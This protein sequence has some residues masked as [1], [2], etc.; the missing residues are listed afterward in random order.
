MKNQIASFYE[1]FGENDAK[2]EVYFAPGRVCLIGEHLDYNGGFVLPAAL[3]IGIYGFVRER[4]DE[5]I[6]LK[7]SLAQKPVEFKI[8]DSIEFNPQDGWA[9]YPKGVARFLREK[10]IE[11]SA[12]EIYFDSD[13]PV[14][15][16]LSSSAALEVLTA[17]ILLSLA[18]VEHI[19]L[20]STALLCKHV[21]NDFVGVKCGIMDQFATGL[22]KKNKGILLNC[23]TEEIQYVDIS[24]KNFQLVVIN[25]NKPRKLSSSDFNQRKSECE[26]ALLHLQKFRDYK[27]LCEATLED[28]KLFND[29]I[30]LKRTRHLITENRRVLSAA[31]SLRNENLKE[32]GKLMTASHRSL[33]NDYEVTGKELDALVSAA[34]DTEGCAGARMTGAGFGGC[35]IAL[36]ENKKVEK[37]KTQ[38]ASKYRVATGLDCETYISKI[39]QGVRKLCAF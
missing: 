16:G 21:E 34:L 19:D 17:F 12:C 26:F 29:E 24:L 33:K 32:F 9:N 30:L 6:V 14:G 20:K 13:L 3:S 38:V 5:K 31:K 25:T 39:G 2:P 15:A 23:A 22:G 1:I 4:T 18:K 36:V 7:S 8:S 37:F 27:H 28:L 35:A 10:K 11:L